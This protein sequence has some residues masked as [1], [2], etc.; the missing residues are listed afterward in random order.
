MFLH[1]KNGIQFAP[2]AALVFNTR[3][4]FLHLGGAT[5]FQHG[6]LH[7]YHLRLEFDGVRTHGVKGVGMK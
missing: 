1:L 2:S 5:D 4:A 6:H 3:A 7:F